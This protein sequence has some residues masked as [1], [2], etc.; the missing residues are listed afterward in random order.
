M[1]TTQSEPS[2]VIA[3][4]GGAGRIL[5]RRWTALNAGLAEALEPAAQLLDAGGEALEA[6]VAAVRI[7][8]SLPAFN[9]GYG[10]VLTTD[11][12]VEA[13]ACVMRGHDL[14]TGAVAALRGFRHP[15]DVARAVMEHTDHVLLAGPGAERFA[16]KRKMEQ[17]DLVE[18]AMRT[19]CLR[20]R[21]KWRKEELDRFPHNTLALAQASHPGTVG[22]VARDRTGGYAAA[23]STGGVILK[24]PGRVGDSAVVGAGNWA[25]RT[26]AISCTGTGESILRSVLAFRAAA[27]IAAGLDAESAGR[28]ALMEGESARVSAGLLLLDTQ[29]RVG[30]VWNTRDMSWTWRSGE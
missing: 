9:A 24:L 17:A 10:S 4:H 16:A 18:P 15:I 25:D 19:R 14:A 28:R 21:R 3:V 11:L 22:A 8:E 13:D 6:V 2:W 7:L 27:A 5:P 30:A 20:L 12:T 26:C 1:N 29:G 23:T